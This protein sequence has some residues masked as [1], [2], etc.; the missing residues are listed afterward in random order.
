MVRTRRNGID[1]SGYQYGRFHETFTLPQGVMSD[2]I[3]A[4]YHNGVLELHLPKSEEAK[5]KRIAVK[6]A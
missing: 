5:A 3:D 2:Q 6:S 1:V 4:R